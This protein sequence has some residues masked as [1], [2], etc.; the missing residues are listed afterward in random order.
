MI[1]TNE[2][3]LPEIQTP[4]QSLFSRL[5]GDQILEQHG[6]ETA[7]SNTFP[8]TNISESDTSY[9]LSMEIPGVAEEDIEVQLHD[10]TLSVVADRKDTR[11][12][13]EDSKRWHRVEHRYGQY[14]R[15][16]S[17]PPDA[18]ADGI[19]AIYKSGVLTVTVPKQEQAQP[20]KI[21]VRTV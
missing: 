2:C 12:E 13:S 7:T 11:K 20:A 14:S 9:E 15:A 19:E 17:L 8:R 10:Q 4:F 5:F 16:I 3:T 6:H 1:L 21:T 18:S